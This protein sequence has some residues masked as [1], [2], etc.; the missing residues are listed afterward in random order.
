MNKKDVLELKKRFTKNG[1]TFTKLAGCYV[2][3][4]KN[5]LVNIDETFLNLE[6]EEFFKYLDIAK[7]TL[8]GKLNNNLLELEFPLKEE[9]PGG[10]QQFLM[11]LRESQL[12][13]PDLL[14]RFFDLI[15]EEYDC[16]GNY[17]I[18]VFHDVYDVIKKTSDNLNLDESEEMYEYLLC[19]ICPVTLS[20]A[21]LG[22]REEEHR[23]G[24][25]IRD[26]VVGV[27]DAGFI[28]PA[29]TD[30]ST[31]I[32]SV[33]FYTKDTKSPHFELM[34]DFLGCP[35]RRTST[36]QKNAFNDMMQNVI[37]T[38]EEV[39]DV[40]LMDIQS[41][42]GGM[43]EE[44][45]NSGQEDV[46]TLNTMVLQNIMTGNGVPESVIEDTIKAYEEEFSGE[47]PIIE[48]LVDAKTLEENAQMKAHKSLIDEVVALKS[49]IAEKNT[50][51]EEKNAIIEQNHLNEEASISLDDTST[52]ADELSAD[53]SS[54][55]TIDTANQTP[56]TDFQINPTDVIVNVNPEKIPLITSQIIDG[57]Q[58][59][60]IPLEVDEHI[61]VNGDEKDV[62]DF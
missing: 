13:N 17:L 37:D 11:G 30:R 19:A 46:L 18:L 38:H 56:N 2:D 29:F 47:T 16:P 52:A 21:A 28:F 3:S 53:L 25:R 4:D 34:E 44:H 27:P 62:A 50:I 57:R 14:D 20:K 43:V 54:D 26:W 42:F 45:E 49:T 36:M 33:M 7:K 39:N 15:I 48:T 32:H 58:C 59:L 22:Y 23:I 41:E 5:K 9:E 1:C 61:R 6:E 10:K 40:M 24:A 55:I 35:A 60:V 51:I 8:S 12:K 31:D